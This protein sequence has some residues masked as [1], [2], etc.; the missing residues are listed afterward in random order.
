M[1]NETDAF[2]KLYPEVDVGGLSRLDGT[3]EF[4]TRIRSLLKPG[5]VV[6]D[7]GAG[8][9]RTAEDPVK[10]RRDLQNLRGDVAK[11]IGVDVDEAVLTNPGL[12]SA[13]VIAPGTRM[14]LDDETVDLIVADSVF[15]HVATPRETASELLRVLR[16]GGWIC[17]RTPN[18]YGY[19]GIGAQLVPNGRHVGWLRLL[20]PG[21]EAR[22]TFPT[23]YLL[24]SPKQLRAAFPGCKTV[25]YTYE[26]PPQYGGNS[27][28]AIRMLAMVNKVM[29]ARLANALMVFIHKP[30]HDAIAVA[31][32]PAS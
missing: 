11:V 4:Y 13:H 26:S 17:A 3:I 14:P 21:K 24:N 12:D 31:P 22:D 5:S 9:G 2:R 19:V 7:F 8:R 32:D 20:Q 18:K 25:I 6:L 16:P 1:S 30:G 10:I 29:P 27:T 28:L 23:Q 15:E